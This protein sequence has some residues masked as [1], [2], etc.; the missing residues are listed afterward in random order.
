MKISRKS[1]IC[2]VIILCALISTRPSES[3]EIKHFEK[4]LQL[5]AR[6]Y[7]KEKDLKKAE[8]FYELLVKKYPS[9]LNFSEVAHF[10]AK[11]KKNKKAVWYFNKSISNL[12]MD[13]PRIEEAYYKYQMYEELLAFYLKSE[14]S[15]E[16]SYLKR[17]FIQQSMQTYK[18]LSQFDKLI[19]FIVRKIDSDKHPTPNYYNELYKLA[20]DEEKHEQ[21][22]AG[23]EKLSGKKN[24]EYKEFMISDSL[25]K[26]Y[27]KLKDF[28]KASKQHRIAVTK[29]MYSYHFVLSLFRSYES[30]KLDQERLSLMD[31]Y[32]M[33]LQKR[34][35][36]RRF[37]LGYYQTLF[38]KGK[39]LKSLGKREDAEKIFLEILAYKR[40]GVIESFKNQSHYE[41]GEI[42]YYKNQYD[43]ARKEFLLMSDV[44]QSKEQYYIARCYMA[45]KRFDEAMKVL[46]LLGNN[47]RALYYSALV[48][49]FQ[50]K[51]KEGIGLL[52]DIA[53]NF[54]HTDRASLALEKL[55][56]IY[57]AKKDKEKLAL[58]LRFEQLLDARK[59]RE[60]IE[61]AT[62]YTK[63][64]RLTEDERAYYQLHFAIIYI[65]QKK[66]HMGERLLITIKDNSTHPFWVQK[67]HFLLGKLY[68]E[69]LRQ[70][71]KG[72]KL[73]KTLVK[74]YPKTLFLLP[75]RELIREHGAKPPKAKPN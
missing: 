1:G 19:D 35:G 43:R 53:L 27:F 42:Y 6:Y 59:Y 41:L 28:S 66:Y 61:K 55:E 14:K 29:D 30:S 47:D 34:K 68:I 65:E 10:Y 72:V 8:E 60:L 52:E 74:S 17:Y 46:L 18:L 64:P 71:E 23:L 12:E 75:A 51:T 54:G 22:I 48:L 45:E 7:D 50:Q 26:I 24:S 49:L 25:G 44:V 56:I 4:E 38:M 67:S 3:A 40:V 9:E 15:V 39:L 37:D 5:K 33:T 31:A 20:I 21:V 58:L 13:Y 70:A 63:D 69:E 73:L 62:L 57:L 32:L 36:K 11:Q 2:F 16:D